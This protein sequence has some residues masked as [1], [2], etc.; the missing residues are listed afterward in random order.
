LSLPL[1]L[2]AMSVSTWVQLARNLASVLVVFI[3]EDSTLLVPLFSDFIAPL[4]SVHGI[5][6]FI[7]FTQM[8]AI[9]LY[10][11]GGYVTMMQSYKDITRCAV[12]T[13]AL[14][15]Y[16][17][18]TDRSE[19]LELLLYRHMLAVERQVAWRSIFAGLCECL[20][21]YAFTFLALNGLHMHS[22]QHPKP[23]MEA[24]VVMECSLLYLL[25]TMVMELALH[26]VNAIRYYALIERLSEG[27]EL[28]SQRDLIKLA[29][30]VGFL[31]N[32]SQVREGF[33]D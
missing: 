24:L 3:P 10:M 30:T 13:S 6:W 1:C 32:L 15:Q 33:K 8:A 26:I 11:E 4:S 18:Y 25:Y 20:I 29:A 21:G 22:P 19:Q 28:K 9:V 2:G 17:L 7:A 14:D 5:G 12:Y 16:Q 31:D 23:L 27:E